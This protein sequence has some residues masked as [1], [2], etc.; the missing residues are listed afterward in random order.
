MNSHKIE[1]RSICPAELLIQPRKP[2]PMTD[3]FLAEFESPANF[4][5]V[6]DHPLST[7]PD[8]SNVFRQSPV[9]R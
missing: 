6:R 8:C 3:N 1:G 4:D 5:R 2:P 7:L 9:A